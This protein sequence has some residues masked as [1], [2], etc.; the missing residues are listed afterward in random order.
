MTEQNRVPA[1]PVE[2]RSDRV[3]LTM[4]A[5]ES[6][7]MLTRM[8]VAGVLAN[9][10]R[11]FDTLEDAQSAAAEACYCLL[12]QPVGYTRLSLC[13]VMDEGEMTLNV[14]GLEPTMQAQRLESM[15]KCEDVALCILQSMVDDVQIDAGDGVIR[16]FTLTR[17]L[18]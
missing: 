2:R 3:E 17:R 6:M 10:S 12:Q 15:R 18:V 11:D 9:S 4:P 8:P 5:R 16:G 1:E 13:L 7:L 14:R